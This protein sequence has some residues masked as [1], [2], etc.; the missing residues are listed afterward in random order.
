MKRLISLVAVA[1]IAAAAAS[2]GWADPPPPRTAKTNVRTE[3]AAVAADPGTRKPDADKLR[4]VVRRLDE[5]LAPNLWV[6]DS[7][8]RSPGGEKVF[9][10]EKEAVHK[11]LELQRDRNSTVDDGTVQGWIDDLVR[12]DYSI[13]ETERADDDP[14]TECKTYDESTIELGKAFQAY[15]PDN[16]VLSAGRPEEAIDHLKHSW[17]KAKEAAKRC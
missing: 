10:R 9:D 1:C 7:H 3:V 8:L 13:T 6:D 14:G 2:A 12:A 11:L 5:S 15:D 4:D 16:P 17:Q